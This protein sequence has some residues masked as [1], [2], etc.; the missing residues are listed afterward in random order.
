MLVCSK[1]GTCPTLITTPGSVSGYIHGIWS[2][3]LIVW[4]QFQNWKVVL[5]WFFNQIH[6]DSLELT[7]NCNPSNRSSANN[8]TQDCFFLWLNIPKWLHQIW[9]CFLQTFFFPK[10]KNLFLFFCRN[11]AFK[12]QCSHPTTHIGIT[13][14][15]LLTQELFASSTP[16]HINFSPMR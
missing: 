10:K 4:D 14:P 9:P 8:Q 2:L 13:I 3:T 6:L 15:A 1:V 7:E 12:Q 11:L 5:N 16:A